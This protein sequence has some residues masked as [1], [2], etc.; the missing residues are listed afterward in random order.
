[1]QKAYHTHAIM[2]QADNKGIPKNTSANAC[3]THSTAVGNNITR[4]EPYLSKNISRPLTAPHAEVI[5][6]S[7]YMLGTRDNISLL[8]AAKPL[9][10]SNI[11]PAAPNCDNIEPAFA[12]LVAKLY[13]HN[14]TALA[15]KQAIANM[16]WTN[17]GQK[18]LHD[19]LFFAFICLHIYMRRYAMR[20]FYN[21]TFSKLVNV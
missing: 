11:H 1:M 18:T 21:T 19:I 13:A 20:T 6:V 9:A 3:T 2:N 5:S 8:L 7:P 15:N 4:E 16:N 14:I 17:I 10:A 12:W